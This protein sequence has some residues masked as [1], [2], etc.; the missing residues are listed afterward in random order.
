MI[1]FVALL[2][3]LLSVWVSWMIDFYLL[4]ILSFSLV[5]SII[6]PFIDMPSAKQS[7]KLRYHSLLF[8]SE[9]PSNGV[10][11]IHG[12]TLFDYVFVIDKNLNGKQR[13]NLI[14]QQYLDGLLNLIQAKDDK[15]ENI[16]VRGTSYIINKRTAERIGFKVTG[17]DYIQKLILTYNYFNILITYSIAKGKLSFPKL[18]D[19]KTFETSMNDLV[20]RKAYISS[21]NEKLKSAM[22]NSL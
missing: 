20:K 14:I 3:I 17:T 22:A 2:V 1:G 16:K 19:T 8:I 13:T 9:K 5:L 7:G 15:T 12:G 21:L 6:A 10:I 4:G 18:T 11:K